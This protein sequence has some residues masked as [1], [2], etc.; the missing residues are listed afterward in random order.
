MGPLVFNSLEADAYRRLRVTLQFSPQVE[1]LSSLV[2]TSPA[3]G[4]GKTTTAINLAIAFVRLAKG[5]PCRWGLKET[6]HSQD[7]GAA[8][9]GR[10][11]KPNNWRRVIGKQCA[12]M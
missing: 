1:N 2:I 11:I 10:V 4:D 6:F 5:S 12:N 7:Y 8:K 3:P 9:Y